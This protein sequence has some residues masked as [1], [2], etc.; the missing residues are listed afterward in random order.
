MGSAESAPEATSFSEPPSR[1][2]R[3]AHEETRGEAPRAANGDQRKGPGNMDLKE[4]RFVGDML[5]G[6]R[7]GYGIQFYTGGSKYEGQW[8]DDKWN[9]TGRF[10][11]KDGDWYQGEWFNNRAHGQGV[12]VHTDG[13]KYEGQWKNNK[14]DGMGVE[15]WSDGS[16]YKVGQLSWPD[17]STYEGSISQEYIH[18]MAF[19]GGVMAEATMVSG[20]RIGCMEE[21]STDGPMAAPTR[22]STHSTKRMASA[23]SDGQMAEDVMGTG[24]RVSSMEEERI[25]RP[26]DMSEAA[27][28]RMAEGYDG[29]TP[30]SGAAASLA[31]D[32]SA[33][34]L[35]RQS[36]SSHREEQSRER[37][38]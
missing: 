29:S 9:G 34:F 12:Y 24:E 14:Q 18:G 28:G 31:R 22:A 16:F 20:A 38:P 7:H 4:G 19:T 21:V 17:G 10:E 2:E 27:N 8:V 25:A 3:G 26:V 1:D 13:T 37:L 11:H 35:R 23:R 30:E 36:P 15:E 6:K 5:A 32:A 33:E